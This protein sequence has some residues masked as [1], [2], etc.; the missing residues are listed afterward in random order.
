MFVEESV[1]VCFE[2]EKKDE[3]RNLLSPAESSYGRLVV[4]YNPPQHKKIPIG[5]NET[6][7]RAKNAT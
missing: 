4:T 7:N 6:S 1:K 3:F 2:F 5:E